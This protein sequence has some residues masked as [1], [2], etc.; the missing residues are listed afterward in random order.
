MTHHQPLEALLRPPLEWYSC[1]FGLGMWLLMNTCPSLLHL[2][3]EYG[4]VLHFGLMIFIVWRFG[5]GCVPC[6]YQ[7]HLKHERIYRLASPKIPHKK[8]QV[9]LGKG[10]Q[11]HTLLTQRLRDLDFAFNAPYVRQDTSG[12]PQLHGVSMREHSV[13]LSD[14]NRSQHMLVLGTTGVGKTRFAELLITQDIQRGDVVIVLDPKGDQAL[15]QRVKQEAKRAGREQQVRVL[16]LGF[17]QHS[18]RYNPIGFYTTGSQVATRL[19]NAL[20]SSGEA[21]AFK[22]FA[23]KY[24]HIVTRGLIALQITPTYRAIQFYLTK[25][26]Q[27]FVRVA[28]A[29]LTMDADLSANF[30]RFNETTKKGAG[31]QERLVAFA[32]YYLKQ[33]GH[34]F[35]GRDPKLQLFNDLMTACRMDRV[36][37][38]KITAS[39]GPLLEKLTAGEL[40][41]L[42]SPEVD[43]DPRPIIDWLS[44]I[45]HQHIVY[46]GLDALSDSLVSAAVGNALLSDLV[47]TAGYLYKHAQHFPHIQ[48]HADEFNEVIGDEFVPLLSK[49]RAAGFTVTAYTQ[50]WSDVE[51]KLISTAKAGQVAGN[52]GSIILFRC[53]DAHTVDRLLDQLPKVPILRTTPVSASSDQAEGGVYFHS[54]NEDRLSYQDMPLIGQNDVINLPK[55]HAFALLQGGRLYKLRMPLLGTDLSGFGSGNDAF[56]RLGWRQ[57]SK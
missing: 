30:Q 20:P 41:D 33:Q 9:F 55:G 13:F 16:H 2:P 7:W 12:Q 3:S 54:N 56:N 42:L 25:L 1:A 10:F 34:E 35:V 24:V 44:V 11:W 43:Q 23:W 49:A 40:A 37:Y 5:Q 8:Q 47:A 50:T 21:A 36:Y 51:A 14:L 27:L 26:D 53:Q 22:E 28:Q 15:L 4:F 19:C 48:L 38:D 52:F 45:E 32:E 46:I 6:Y 17:P 57:K 31:Y 39:I 29:M 18:C